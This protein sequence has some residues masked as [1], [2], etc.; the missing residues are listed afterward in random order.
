[1]DVYDAEI[2][3]L[4]Q[5]LQPR[6]PSDLAR[7]IQRRPQR[8]AFQ[9]VINQIIQ[10]PY[11]RFFRA[12]QP[13]KTIDIEI[14]LADALAVAQFPTGFN[15]LLGVI[16]PNGEERYWTIRRDNIASLISAL[17]RDIT[18]T[19]V[20]DYNEVALAL[21]APAAVFFKWKMVGPRKRPTGGYF[22]YYNKLANVD[23]SRYGI[24][25]NAAETDEY[26]LNCLEIAVRNAGLDFNLAARVLKTRFVPQKEL[27]KLAELLK[28]EIHL[29]KV[30]DAKSRV[31]IYQCLPEHRSDSRLHLG[32]L[33]EH[34]FLIEPTKYTSYSITNYFHVGHIKGFNKIY[35]WDDNYKTS[36]KRFVDSFKIVSLLLE[37]MD[38]HLEEIT[39][40]NCGTFSTYANKLS[41]GEQLAA[42]T[43]KEIERAPAESM[44]APPRIFRDRSKKEQMQTIHPLLANML[45]TVAYKKI[46]AQYVELYGEE[47]HPLSLDEFYLNAFKAIYKPN[48][49]TIDKCFEFRTYKE[50]GVSFTYITVR[51]YTPPSTPRYHPYGVL[52]LDTEASP[53]DVHRP[54]FIASDDRADEETN[55]QKHREQFGDHCILNWLKSLDRNYICIAHNLRYDFQFVL[56][57]LSDA[58]DMIKTGNMLKSISGKFY[59]TDTDKTILL[60]FKDSYSFIPTKLADFAQMFNLSITKDAMPYNAYTSKTLKQRTIPLRQAIYHVKKVDRCRFLYNAK[61]HGLINSSTGAAFEPVEFNHIEYA[62]IYCRRDVQ[63]LKQGYEKFRQWI[64]EAT[65]I[66][67]DNAVSLPQVAH[68]HGINSGVFEGCYKISG[69]A[70]H[71]I[72]QCVVGGR[73]MTRRNEMIDL[74]SK[75]DAMDFTSLYPSAMAVMDGFLKDTPKPLQ[76]DGI[77]MIEQSLVDHKLAPSAQHQGTYETFNYQKLKYIVEHMKNFDFYKTSSAD[78]QKE[79]FDIRPRLYLKKATEI[80]G[81]GY[82]DVAYNNKEHGRCHAKGALSLQMLPRP[83]RHIIASEFYYDIDMVNAGPTI[84]SYL[85]K[86]H[87]ISC[88]ALDEYINNRDALMNEIV[89]ENPGLNKEAVKTLIIATLNGGHNPLAVH[90]KTRWLMDFYNEMGEI[91]DAIYEL[92]KHDFRT[93]DWYHKNIKGK[94]LNKQTC[95]I[96]NQMLQAI[97]GFLKEMGLQNNYV[98]CFDGIM[99][100]K[101]LF[102]KRL[103]EEFAIDTPEQAIEYIER[104]LQETF[105]INLR[106]KNKPMTTGL[107]EFN[108]LKKSFKIGQVKDFYSKPIDG[109]F[110]EIE[111]LDVGKRRDFPLLSRIN[112]KGVREFSNDIRGRGI[113]VD[114]TSLQDLVAFQDVKFRVLRGYYFDEGR[115]TRINSFMR[116]MFELR[117]QKKKEGNPIQ[118]AYKLLM[119]SFYGKL[120]QKPIE[121]DYRFIF[122]EKKMN[123][124][125]AYNFNSIENYTHIG[126]DIYYVKQARSVL[127]HFSMPHCGVEVLSMSKRLMNMPMCLA[128]DLKIPIY[129]QDTDSMHICMEEVYGPNK[130]MSGFAYLCQQYKQ[131]YGHQLDGGNLGQMHSDFDD[132]KKEHNSIT[133]PVAIRSIYLGKKSYIDMIQL[134]VASRKKITS[135][136]TYEKITIP[137]IRMKSIPS[138]C[139]KYTAEAYFGGNSLELYEHFYNHN[140]C[141]FDIANVCKFKVHNHF[142]TMNNMIFLRRICFAGEREDTNEIDILKDP[143]YSFERKDIDIDDI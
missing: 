135:P 54:Y 116:E 56:P 12:P 57:F 137:H 41:A 120:I 140:P 104:R 48:E 39:M 36:N 33:D 42:P 32:L 68:V 72:Q 43:E 38:T 138:K 128:E 1:M 112:D 99:V 105:G 100:P 4:E 52:Y 113:F 124:Y 44:P 16:Q 53:Y 108:R 62:K 63:V 136:P 22:K 27:Q 13:G 76:A 78:I 119:N 31:T 107:G 61:S 59:N 60:H 21:R 20:E 123:K 40:H 86:K 28:V 51:L 11:Q 90:N 130:N 23:L 7:D 47:P 6:L 115:N 35:T 9:P 98:L 110:V 122:G 97:L 55:E 64:L 73:C 102:S 109:Y 118:I 67:I 142:M 92:Y 82:I 93:N 77:T 83:I 79:F 8:V 139:I 94:V 80:D 34:Y 5:Q 85:C 24:Y 14:P 91:L 69:E 143:Y 129:Y 26:A 106:L 111:V 89:A 121:H 88:P 46:L 10:A 50:V 3:R 87:S 15:L 30:D 132:I 2:R 29:R 66:D 17:Q 126:R 84:L 75:T 134:T 19:G 65:N 81:I 37:H 74:H 127:E 70:R 133:N 125:L 101:S 103:S 141:T 71:F 18:E 58:S 131:V 95:I 114:K 96:E 117:R 45:Q 25:H 49:E